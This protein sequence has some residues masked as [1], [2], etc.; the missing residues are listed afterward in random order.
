[1]IVVIFYISA[2][3]IGSFMNDIID[4]IID[5]EQGKDRVSKCEYCNHSLRWYD[6]IPVFSYLSTLGRC[7]YCKQKL[8]MRYPLVELGAV[9]N[10][11]IVYQLYEEN[12][13]GLFFFIYFCLMMVLSVIDLILKKVPV[14]A[15]A[16]IL[17]LG[18]LSMLTSDELVL[19]D[20]ICA[21]FIVSV[22]LF[23]IAKL[24]KN[25]IG[26]G[27][28][29]FCACSGFLLGM[30]GIVFTACFAYIIGGIYAVIMLLI[31]QY[32]RNSKVA[33]FPFFYMAAVIFL[34]YASDFIH[35]TLR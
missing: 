13:Q 19:L 15:M 34:T 28:I 14:K 26:E 21:V 16:I 27:D 29:L 3:F 31:K 5:K 30:W 11:L 4:Y 24:K 9:A 12:I 7:R 33:M 17:V 6:K 23:V 35:I 18:I 20:R 8:S 10:F 1:M 22:P 25:S 32:D 2:F